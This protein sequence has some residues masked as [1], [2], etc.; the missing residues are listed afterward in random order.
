MTGEETE[1]ADEEYLTSGEAGRILHVSAKTV[2]RWADRGL[3]AH[4]V[5]LG[6]H[7]RFSRRAIA[8]VQSAMTPKRSDPGAVG[9]SE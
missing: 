4:V 1:E 6:G 9:E 2:D 5:T 7:R 8:K 3:I